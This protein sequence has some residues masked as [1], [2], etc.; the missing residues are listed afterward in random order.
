[1]NG[2]NIKKYRD[3]N[4]ISQ[5]ELAKKL[6]I[7]RSTLARW[8]K[9]I[10]SPRDDDYDR[11]REIMGDEYMN[12]I[13]TPIRNDAIEAI[14]DVSDRVDNILYQV[15]QIES[16]QRS[17]ETENNKSM[18]KH[19]RIRTIAVISVCVIIIIIC[20][21]TWFFVL[22]HGIRDKGIEGSAEMGTP[23]YFEIDDET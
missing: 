2:K 22:N 20:L 21:Y 18:L 17:F 7:A 12:D 5:I 11:L 19:R 3:D 6:G 15:T 4:G 1:M 13:Q 10:T 23:S 16:N 14:E 9:N 8:E